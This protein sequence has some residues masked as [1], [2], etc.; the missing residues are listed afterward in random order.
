MDGSDDEDKQEV[1]FHRNYY[2]IWCSSSNPNF[3]KPTSM[4]DSNQI[5]LFVVEM[6]RGER[7]KVWCSLFL[8][9]RMDGFKDDRGE[10]EEII[11][12]I[13]RCIL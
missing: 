1:N 2:F 8:L 11:C 6:E 12:P 4:N 13:N 7:R 10:E 3:W 9:G 5:M